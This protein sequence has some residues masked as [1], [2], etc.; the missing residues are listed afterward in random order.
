MET[1][2]SD[3]QP[4][5]LP[6]AAE[7]L[8]IE[9]ALPEPDWEAQARSI[10]QR[11]A[12]G[13]RPSVVDGLLAA[14]LPS[15][16]AA[17]A[18]P[19]TDPIRAP[20]PSSARKPGAE[21]PAASGSLAALARQ[22]AKKS[23]RPDATAIARESLSAA[24][25]ARANNDAVVERVRAS[26]PV[27][28]PRA[29]QSAAKHPPPSAASPPAPSAR[30]AVPS[31]PV[32]PSATAPA[33]DRP[34][35][36][37]WG[38]AVGGLGLAAAVA[39]LV[40][41]RQPAQTGS[42]GTARSAPTVVVEEAPVVKAAP[43]PASPP[44][45]AAAAVPPVAPVPPTPAA[46]VEP[47]AVAKLGPVPRENAAPATRPLPAASVSI[48]RGTPAAPA[49]PA[50]IVLEETPPAVARAPVNPA[51]RPAEG[52]PVGGLPSKPSTGAVQAAIGSVMGS[53]KA[54]LAGSSQSA[55]V[56]L[57][58]GSNGSVVGANVKGPL[59]GSSAAQCIEGALRR[60]RVSPFADPIF[61]LGMWVRP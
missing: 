41:T 54:C 18:P 37:S 4:P 43:L 34:A 45:S 42:I 24:L 53:A 39:L 38:F 60:A 40:F 26:R 50:A 59:A 8:L 52:T 2:M 9:S 29:A 15:E 5:R 61:S 47:S 11:L 1:T 19:Q 46:A 10:E 16:S 49:A 21:A 25:A 6:R 36:S 35:R 32:T 20:E 27:A 28:A 23:S 55:Q 44:A 17:A 13:A 3:E 14:P 7:A 58:F 51:L 33:Q 31:Q 48:G 12:E 30:A 56:E 22:V 57:T